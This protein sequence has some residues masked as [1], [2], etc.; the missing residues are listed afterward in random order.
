MSHYTVLTTRISDPLYLAEAI[1]DMGYEQVEVWDDPQPLI[2][3]Q[4]EET[5]QSA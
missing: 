1:A 5:M 3:Y 2:D 4:G